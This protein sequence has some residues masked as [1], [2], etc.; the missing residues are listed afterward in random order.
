MEKHA[1]TKM[2]S[3]K[4]KKEAFSFLDLKGWGGRFSLLRILR[5]ANCYNIYE[6]N[7]TAPGHTF[8]NFQIHS[9]RIRVLY[10][11]V[12]YFLY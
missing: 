9:R 1:K 2:K 8:F 7:E 6:K 3:T 12:K 10:R 4:T 5:A 11:E